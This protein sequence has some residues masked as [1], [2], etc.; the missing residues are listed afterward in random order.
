MRPDGV[1]PVLTPEEV[2]TVDALQRRDSAIRQE[3]QTRASQ[4]GAFAGAPIYQYEV[5]PDDKRYA[6][7]GEVPVRVENPPS[8]AEQLKRV[9]HDSCW[10]V[11]FTIADLFFYEGLVF[12]AECKAH[13]VLLA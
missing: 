13:S 4:A 2:R 9:R 11:E 3:E 10:V 5:G 6:V 12:R 7:S 1:G 8:D